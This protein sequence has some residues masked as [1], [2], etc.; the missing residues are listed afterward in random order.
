MR[1]HNRIWLVGLSNAKVNNF[2]L[3]HMNDNKAREVV[4]KEVM[5]LRAK[6]ET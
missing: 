2:E 3:I 4:K 6:R 5:G 1:L